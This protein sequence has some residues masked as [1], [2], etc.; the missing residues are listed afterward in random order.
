MII[1]QFG[2]LRNMITSIHRVPFVPP[3]QSPRQFIHGRLNG[4]QRKPL[5][6]APRWLSRG[7]V[8]HVRNFQRNQ[9]DSRW[10]PRRAAAVRR[11]S[12]LDLEIGTITRKCARRKQKKKSRRRKRGKRGAA[13]R[14]EDALQLAPAGD[15]RRDF[16]FGPVQPRGS[17]L[18]F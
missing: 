2:A 9:P 1:L 14:D 6:K 8:T 18:L 11:S 3:M 15:V 13:A 10:A 5:I 16:L 12:Y 4:P 7:R 17:L